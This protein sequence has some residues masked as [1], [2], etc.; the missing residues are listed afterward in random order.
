MNARPHALP[1]TLGRLPKQAPEIIRTVL[2]G[3][4]AGI[5]LTAFHWAVQWMEAHGVHRL[6]GQA[7]WIFIVGTFALITVGALLASIVVEKLAPEA[8]GG[9]VMP[10]KVAF[11]KRGGAMQWRVALAKLVGSLLTLGCGVSLG[12]E[13][14]AVQIGAATSS[15]LARGLGQTGARSSRSA[16]AGGAAAGIAAAFGAPISAVAFVLEEI[17]GDL[18]SRLLGRVILMAVTSSL[19][20]RAV[21]GAH[22]SFGGLQISSPTLWGWLLVAPVAAAASL[23][24]VAFGNLAL[25]IRSRGK[26]FTAV[27]RWLQPVFGAWTTWA[28]GVAAFLWTGHDGVFGTGYTD[29]TAALAG[30]LTME[31]TAVLLAG[32]IVATAAAVGVASCGGVF[33]PSLFIGGMCGALM[34]AVVKHFLPTGE[35]DLIL[36]VAAGM[37]ASLGAVIRTPFTVVLLLFE[38]T[39][40]YLFVPALMLA[41]AISVAVSHLFNHH[42]IY[43]EQLVQDGYDPE[44]F[45]PVRNPRRWGERPIGSFIQPVGKGTAEGTPSAENSSAARD[46]S[47]AWTIR[48][49]NERVCV[50]SF[51]ADLPVRAVLGL[52][53][54]A[55]ADEAVVFDRSTGAFEGVVTLRELAK[56]QT[57]LLEQE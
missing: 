1:Q 52:L 40:Q 21:L 14:P 41:S 38:L 51:P 37:A 55:E 2:L 47:G 44:S 45:L 4:A 31:E 6:A 42:G 3:A 53:L 16:C 9:G 56:A 33:A 29:L 48:R 5:V 34:G 12:P 17:I 27:P 10:T 49:G 30:H 39:G 13:G 20:A 11:W 36:W 23:S 8:H 32:K 57:A 26:R 35:A 54:Q 7:K 50:P 15:S 22:A 25:S 19:I 46:E 43:E 24:G 18:S 28:I